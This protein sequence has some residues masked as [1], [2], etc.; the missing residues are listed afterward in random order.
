M[1]HDARRAWLEAALDAAFGQAVRTERIE[2][3]EPWAVARCWLRMAAD[4]PPQCV[5]GKWLRDDPRGARTDP[6]QIATE[7][8]ALEFLA[9]IG[10]AHAPRLIAVDPTNSL[11]VMEDLAPRAPL[12]DRL[13]LEGVAAARDDLLAYARVLG[14]LGAATVGKAAR[15]DEVRRAYGPVDPAV[16]GE[17]GVGPD[18]SKAYAVL[19]SLGVAMP[20][21][22]EDDLAAALEVLERPGDFLALSNGDTQVNNFLVAEGDGKLIDYEGASYRHAVTSAVL[23]HV[24]GSAWITVSEPFCADLEDAYRKTLSVGTPRADDDRVFGMAMAA[25]CL[26][27]ALDR[28]GRFRL[29]DARAPGEGSRVQMVSTL[30]AAASVARRHRSLI[31]LAGW[32]DRVA[33]WLRARWPD[34]DADL[35]AYRPYTP[36]A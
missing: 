18:W 11:L 33:G 17:R 31:H 23:L 2:R 22:A 6:R 27:Y 29:L 15:Y 5:I 24:P 7:R 16:A 28:L 8:A 20:T 25:A 30:E 35:S 26:A 1:E 21:A 19:Q 14:E 4:A 32:A 10:F 12:A 36:R 13:R 3:L 34:A 9:E